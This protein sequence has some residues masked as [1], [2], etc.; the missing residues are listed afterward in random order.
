[1]AGDKFTS[2]VPN[3]DPYPIL[4]YSDYP[5]AVPINALSFLPTIITKKQTSRSASCL[6]A[7]PQKRKRPEKKP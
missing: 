6:I 5:S 3:F 2:V 1:M 7:V 4:L